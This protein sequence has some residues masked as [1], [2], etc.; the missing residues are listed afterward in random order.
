[1][2][3]VGVT[4]RTLRM[5]RLRLSHAKQMITQSQKGADFEGIVEI[6]QSSSAAFARAGDP[7][8]DKSPF[9]P[10]DKTAPKRWV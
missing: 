1:M 9:V 7:S 5:L 8:T 6:V 3:Q 10:W 4:L 2:M